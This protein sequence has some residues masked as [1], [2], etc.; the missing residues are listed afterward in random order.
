MGLTEKPCHHLVPPGPLLRRNCP[1]IAGGFLV[2]KS[3]ED[4]KPAAVMLRRSQK[5]LVNDEARGSLLSFLPSSTG[6]AP[7]PFP[8]ELRDVASMVPSPSGRYLAVVRVRTKDGKK[9]QSIEV[10]DGGSLQVTVSGNGEIHG[11]VYN[12]DVFSSLEWD[13]D[14][15]RLMYVAECKAPETSSFWQA[16]PAASTSWEGARWG[17]PAYEEKK[18]RG[19]EFK[20]KGD[21]GELCTGKSLSRLFVLHVPTGDIKQVVN[22][23]CGCAGLTVIQSV[24]NLTSL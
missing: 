14:E 21:W 7:Q 3:E 1:V 24:S 2:G 20:Y 15:T 10:W 6:F 18:G 19:E 8:T 4:G 12:G 22:P 16:K 13:H 11:A 5:D 9:E 23:C 17:G